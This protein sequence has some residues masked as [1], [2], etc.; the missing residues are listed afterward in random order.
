MLYKIYH[1]HCTSEPVN[2]LYKIKLLVLVFDGIPDK[3]GESDKLGC[4]IITK[5]YRCYT[6]QNAQVHTSYD[7]QMNTVA[8]SCK[9]I[10]IVSIDKKRHGDTNGINIYIKIK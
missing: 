3:L 4:Y 10:V 6:V 9:I 1:I 2:V 5:V 8:F 7:A